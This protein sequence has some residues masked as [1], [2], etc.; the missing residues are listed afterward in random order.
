M[1]NYNCPSCKRY[2]NL[3]GYFCRIC[4]HSVKFDDRSRQK[5][6]QTYV[7]NEKYCDN[8]GKKRHSGS[9]IRNMK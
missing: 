9:C 2:D 5:I 6:A 8:C 7:T 4:G 1:P 3:N